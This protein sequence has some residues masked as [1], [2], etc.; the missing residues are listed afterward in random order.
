M[1]PSQ[2]LN[3]VLGRNTDTGGVEFWRQPER[4]GWLMKQGK[5]RDRVATPVFGLSEPRLHVPCPPMC[6][7][8]QASLSRPGGEGG[9]AA[10]WWAAWRWRRRRVR[11]A[12]PGAHWLNCPLKPLSLLHCAVTIRRWFVL[13]DG[14]IFWFKTDIVGPVSGMARLSAGNSPARCLLLNAGPAQAAMP[15]L[16]RPASCPPL[17]PAPVLQRACS[18]L[19]A[20]PSVHV[21][22]APCPPCLLR[23][24]P[25]PPLRALCRA[26][27]RAGSSR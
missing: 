11:G 12:S 2:L 18:Y 20:R 23:T 13:K 9:R 3:R 10:Q 21:H 24:L 5:P 16:P 17:T 1:E 27:S 8:L 7:L 22:P 19:G 15:Y 4:S 6:P 25:A 26:R 14:K